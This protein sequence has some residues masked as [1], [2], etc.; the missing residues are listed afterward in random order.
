MLIS[1][2]E[3]AKKQIETA[4]VLHKNGDDIE[5]IVLASASEELLG[6][7]C[8]H[9]ELENSLKSLIDIS[10]SIG[11]NIREKDFINLLNLT[12][13]ELKHADDASVMHVDIDENDAY[14]AIVRALINFKRLGLVPTE[15]IEDFIRE[16]N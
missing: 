15:I 10:K 7:I 11:Q 13:N 1:K 14:I 2:I 5:A 12:K 6:N 8:K 16:V 4:I 3:V 9:K